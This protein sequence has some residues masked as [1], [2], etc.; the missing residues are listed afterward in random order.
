[1]NTKLLLRKLAYYFPKRIAKENHDY[2]GIMVP[3]LKEESEKLWNK[4]I[5]LEIH[6]KFSLLLFRSA[7]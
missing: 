3:K 1:M 6:I 4:N 7:R 5:S 2:V